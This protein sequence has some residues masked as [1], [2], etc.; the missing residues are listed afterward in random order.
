M[1]RIEQGAERSAKPRDTIDQ[2][3]TKPATAGVLQQSSPC[4]A[5]SERERTRKALVGIFIDH[6]ILIEPREA[7]EKITLRVN[8]FTFR[9]IFR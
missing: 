5:L 7:P 4:R 2:H 6:G 3:T 1:M 8:R 9:L